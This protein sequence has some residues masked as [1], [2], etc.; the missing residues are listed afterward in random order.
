MYANRKNEMLMH[1][2][3]V[4]AQ[5][6]TSRSDNIAN[7]KLC[8]F[9]RAKPSPPP[10][11]CVNHIIDQFL[12]NLKHLL[13]P[14]GISAYRRTPSPNCINQLIRKRLNHIMIKL[15]VRTKKGYEVS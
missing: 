12:P 4:L 1:V 10:P 6:S 3:S 7:W 5:S 14:F 9:R 8:T 11:Y 15:Q 2:V 13:T